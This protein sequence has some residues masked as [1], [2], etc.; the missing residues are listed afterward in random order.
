MSRRTE[1]TKDEV[2]S[3]DTTHASVGSESQVPGGLSALIEEAGALHRT[4]SDARV[5]AGRLVAALRRHRRRERLVD[6]TLASLRALEL[7]DVAR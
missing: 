3:H 6:T 7:Q 1:A 2:G 4:L 5:R